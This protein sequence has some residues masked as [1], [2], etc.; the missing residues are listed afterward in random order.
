MFVPVVLLIGASTLPCRS[1][2]NGQTMYS[3]F[4]VEDLLEGFVH[5]Q[6]CKYSTYPLYVFQSLLLPY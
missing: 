4:V 3:L 2:G 5:H 1:R 6:N